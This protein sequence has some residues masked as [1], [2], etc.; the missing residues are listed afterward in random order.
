MAWKSESPMDQKQQFV[1]L[2][3]SGKFHISELCHDFG[4]SRKTGHKYLNRYAE[5][6]T[7]GLQ[8][9]SRRPHSSPGETAAAV[10][11]L[12]LK[13]RREHATW[14]PK[15]IRQLL[16]TKHAVEFPPSQSTIG[17]I[18]KRNG[19]IK[20]RRRKAPGVYRG[21]GEELTVPEQPNEVWTVDYK[22]WFLLGNG[23]RCDPLTVCDRYSHYIIECKARSN[24]QHV[25]TL[26]DFKALMKRYGIPRIIR[27]DNG[28]PFASCG[29]GGLS[30][31]SVWWIKQGIAVEFT[32]PGCPQDNGSHER[33]HK[34][35][36]AEP[37]KPASV[38]MAAQQRRLQRWK[39]EYNEL[40]PHESLS[41]GV[42]A[43]YYRRSS[44]RLGEDDRI[45][46]P[47]SYLKRRINENGYLL[48]EGLKYFVGEALKRCEV[49]LHAAS[50][51]VIELHFANLHLGNLAFGQGQGHFRD[52]PY[53]S[54]PDDRSY[55]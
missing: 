30:R 34:D 2:A 46:Y 42:P 6:G 36:K 23:E 25:G 52:T 27:V 21:E 41:M 51:G 13:L 43:D 50:D 32:R 1:H 24:Q 39:K 40:R 4:I 3:N 47:K 44:R 22:G 11:K 9:R 45:R 38:N 15:K 26:R 20:A 53:I 18:L 19:L 54:R 8:D 5:H 10:E 37:I 33:M 7:A 49:G 31:L 17:E 28:F 29:I 48:H 35:L 12:A 16:I 55:S 14:G